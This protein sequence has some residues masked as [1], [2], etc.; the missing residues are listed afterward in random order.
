MQP[1]RLEAGY[2]LMRYSRRHPWQGVRI[3]HGV[4]PDPD[5]P[6]NAMDRSHL[7]HVEV[8]GEEIEPAKHLDT[9]LWC[10]KNPTD[11]ATHDY[12]VACS[13]RRGQPEATPDRAIDHH[14]LKPIF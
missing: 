8:N 1:D 4:T 2:Y 9:W 5:F 12:Y 3:W 11:K 13:K 14:E 7:W 10:A 6:D